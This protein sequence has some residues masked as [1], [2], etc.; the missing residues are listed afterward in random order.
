MMDTSHIT[1]REF[2]EWLAAAKPG[3][4]LVV[5]MPEP[6]PVALVGELLATHAKVA[7]IAAVLVNAAVPV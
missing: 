1:A 4:V 6:R 5:T 2:G 7:G 3:E